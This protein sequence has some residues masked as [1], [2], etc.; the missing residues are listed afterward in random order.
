MKLVEPIIDWSDVR[1]IKMPTL[2]GVA[3]EVTRHTFMC[4]EFEIQQYTVYGN[5][6]MYIEDMVKGRG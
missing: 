1:C 2:K 3:C 5:T 4:T 6:V